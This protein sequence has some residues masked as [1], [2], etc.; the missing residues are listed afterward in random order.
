[1]VIKKKWKKKAVLSIRGGFAAHMN[2]NE[3]NN[4]SK[5]FRK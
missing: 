3:A 4:Q 1:M 5:P 2:K